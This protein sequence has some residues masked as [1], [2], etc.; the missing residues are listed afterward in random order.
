MNSKILYSLF[1]AMIVSCT[2]AG[3]FVG[4]TSAQTFVKG[5]SASEIFPGSF[6]SGSYTF[7]GNLN[8]GG[9]LS[10]N[11]VCIGSDCRNS[12]PSGGGLSGT[13]TANYIPKWTGSASLGNS[14]IYQDGS[15]IKINGRLGT[16]GKSPSCPNGWGCGVHT[17]DIY[18]EGAIH[19][20]KWIETNDKICIQGDCR[21]SWPGGKP[22]ITW[23]P[24]LPMSRDQAIGSCSID[25][26]SEGYNLGVHDVCMVA[27]FKHTNDMNDCLVWKEGNV[28][29]GDGWQTKCTWVC[30]DW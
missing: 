11:T 14:V 29:K 28:W 22:T 5:H 19:A 26:G 24:C 23:Y 9:T 3:Y 20:D 30:F 1:A 27:N 25:P 16:N 2:L 4:L 18:A 13:G 17:Y 15:D 6:Q 8:I 12:W 21:T 7:P 10:A